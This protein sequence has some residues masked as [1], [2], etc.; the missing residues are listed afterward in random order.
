METLIIRIAQLISV[1]ADINYIRNL[2]IT[3][4]YNDETIF[5]GYKAAQVFLENPNDNGLGLLVEI[6][7]PLLAR[8]DMSVLSFVAR[9]HLLG[10]L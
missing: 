8:C 5:L 6:L 4:G 10:L 7:R 3:E 1:G 9:N 2:L